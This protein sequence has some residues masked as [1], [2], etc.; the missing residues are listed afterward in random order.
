[1]ANYFVTQLG[2]FGL[3]TTNLTRTG[4][5]FADDLQKLRKDDLVIMLA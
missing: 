1:M 4:L 5:L 3:D 2:R